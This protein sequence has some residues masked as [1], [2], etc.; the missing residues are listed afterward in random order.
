MIRMNCPGCGNTVDREAVF[1]ARCGYSVARKAVPVRY[2][3]FAARV[4]ATAIDLLLMGPLVVLFFLMVQESPAT[5]VEPPVVAGYVTF[6][7][8]RNAVKLL[9]IAF[10]VGC[11]YFTFMESSRH[12]GTVGKILLGLKVTGLNGKRIGWPRA[13][14]RYFARWISYLPFWFGFLMP[15]FTERKQ[16]LHDMISGCLVVKTG[17]AS[18]ALE[19]APT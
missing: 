6:T 2:A 7:D 9:L 3:S 14:G 10:A 15:L 12:Q 4:A 13:N 5:T 8:M 17:S 19:E 11:P 16:A 1:C 18:P